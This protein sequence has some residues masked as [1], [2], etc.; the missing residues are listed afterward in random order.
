M[1]TSSQKVWT[2]YELNVFSFITMTVD[3]M[4]FPPTQAKWLEDIVS[5]LTLVKNK[6]FIAAIK[7][8][9]SGDVDSPLASIQDSV[10]TFCKP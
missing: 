3:K 9:A 1:Y 8:E 7:Q 4:T 10:K 6:I 5:C 2:P